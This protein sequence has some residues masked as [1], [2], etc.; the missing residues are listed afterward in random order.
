MPAHDG[1][2][3][4]AGLEL[5]EQR[6]RHHDGHAVILEGGIE[7]VLQ[8]QLHPV[9]RQRVGIVFGDQRL[10]LPEHVGEPQVEQLRVL[11]LR[12]LAPGF[13]ALAAR[14]RRRQALIEEGDARLLVR[15]HVALARLVPQP[16]HLLQE[17]AVLLLEGALGLVL[18]AHQRVLDEH[19]P[20]AHGRDGRVVNAAVLQ[21]GQAVESS[22][23]ADLGATGLLRPV[24]LGVGALEQVSAHAIEPVGIEAGHVAREQLRGLH[25]LVRHDPGGRL[26]R[27]ARRRMDHEAGLARARVEAVL[28]VVH[29]DAREQTREQRLMQGVFVLRADVADGLLSRRRGRR[30]RLG[31]ARSSAHVALRAAATRAAARATTAAA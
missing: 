2:V 25:Q 20:R 3:E 24:R 31:C 4:L 23:L 27:Q 10:A 29:A 15:Q 9:Q 5:Q 30:G 12:L 18:A 17:L 7:L 11:L 13:E 22:V 14:H 28:G 8:G 6:Q 26:L 16:R 19:Q 1:P 21:H